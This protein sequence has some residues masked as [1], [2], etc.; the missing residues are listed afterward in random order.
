MTSSTKTNPADIREKVKEYY[1]SLQSSGDLKTDVCK[2][3]NAPRPIQAI[4]DELPSEICDKF[5][6]C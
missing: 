4:I 2:C 5:Y 3:G 1:S 6:G